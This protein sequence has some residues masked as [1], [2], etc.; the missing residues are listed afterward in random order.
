MQAATGAAKLIPELS[1]PALGQ[2]R[3]RRGVYSGYGVV[4]TKVNVCVW[5]LRVLSLVWSLR[6]TPVL[7]R[8][9]TQSIKK[10]R[11]FAPPPPA[12]TR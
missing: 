3:P 2:G 9:A 1:W 5:L 10:V 8:E 7:S 6:I 12:P 11:C 4:C